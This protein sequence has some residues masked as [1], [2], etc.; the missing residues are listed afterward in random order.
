MNSMER[1]LFGVTLRSN[2][3]DETRYLLGVG[4]LWTPLQEVVKCAFHTKPTAEYHVHV[5]G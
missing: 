4:E 1:E 2:T 5:I 3:D